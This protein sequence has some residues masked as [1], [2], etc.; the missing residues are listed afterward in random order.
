MHLCCGVGCQTSV[1][2]STTRLAK[3][4]SVP[5]NISGEYSKLQS[6]PGCCAASSR[7]RRACVTASCTTPSSSRPSTTR[8]ITGAVALYRC[9]MA[10]GAPASASKVRRI[11]SSRACVSTWIVTSSGISF[12]SISRRTKSKSACEADGKPTSIS[13]KPMRTS[14]SNMRSLRAGSI[15]SISAWLPSRR[16]T[17]HHSGGRSS[18][19]SGQRLSARRTGAKARY[20]VAG[21]VSMVMVEPRGWV[22]HAT[23]TKANGPLRELTGR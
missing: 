15:G 8:R 1:T 21:W 3:S 2:A 5:E 10:R 9:T 11:S 6:V 7:S 14:I 13:L 23:S 22:G 19:A 17:L 18:T 20:L 4:S 16:S 12:C